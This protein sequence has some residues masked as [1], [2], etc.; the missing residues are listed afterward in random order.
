MFDN[1]GAKD[2]NFTS[3]F[4]KCLLQTFSA[5]AFNGSFHGLRNTI[6][7]FFV[8]WHFPFCK[9]CIRTI[10]HFFWAILWRRFPFRRTWWQHILANSILNAISCTNITCIY[11]SSRTVGITMFL[12]W[13]I[14]RA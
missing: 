2:R 1:F 10:G 9:T 4:S 12:Q 7:T 6:G 11:H 13:S 8:F 3:Y 5:F 14:F